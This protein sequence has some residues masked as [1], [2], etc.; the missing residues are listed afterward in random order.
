MAKM[1][2]NEEM[3]HGTI[4]APPTHDPE[5]DATVLRKAMK[6]LGKGEKRACFS[7]S[8][9]LV[10]VCLMV[11]TNGG[12]KR[13]VFLCVWNVTHMHSQT[14]TQVQVHAH[15]LTQ[16]YAY[17]KHSLS[18][19]LTQTHTHSHTH[20]HVGTDER[21]IINLLVTRTNVQRQAIRS[22]FKLMYGKVSCLT[23]FTMF[24]VCELNNQRGYSIGD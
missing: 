19:S 4:K 17:S 6:G 13:M 18:L 22:R 1:S 3:G 9:Y 20:T 16:S 15:K 5:Q 2:V 21:T 7:V 11:F 10:G 14:Q 8:V 23:D 12:L 24:K